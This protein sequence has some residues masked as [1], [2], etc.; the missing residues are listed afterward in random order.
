MASPS[1]ES[2]A[3]EA[4]RVAASDS[5]DSVA[6]IPSEQT[7][8]ISSS[9]ANL[10]NI[11]FLIRSYKLLFPDWCK[12]CDIE[13]EPSQQSW[14]RFFLAQGHWF[15]KFS[16]KLSFQLS[17][18][19]AKMKGNDSQRLL[20]EFDHHLGDWKRGNTATSSFFCRHLFA[21]HVLKPHLACCWVTKLKHE[22][23]YVYMYIS[24]NSA[25]T[26]GHQEH[27]WNTL[28][29]LWTLVAHL[30]SQ[31]YLRGH[32][33]GRS[34][35]RA[36][37]WWEPAINFQKTAHWHQWALKTCKKTRKKVNSTSKTAGC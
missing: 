34:R 30:W 14:F 26:P 22:K 21:K 13:K 5:S 4:H 33:N 36:R 31:G 28:Q 27:F 19:Q 25:L 20:L 29:F 1:H 32:V 11:Y 37:S 9:L 7:N 12:K 2:N 23:V 35:I 16:F 17:T 6:S 24:K 15:S 3:P 18:T 8:E 10:A